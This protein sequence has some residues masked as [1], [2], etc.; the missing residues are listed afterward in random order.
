M[1]QHP[2]CRM[3]MS[4]NENNDSHCINYKHANYEKK[5][6]YTTAMIGRKR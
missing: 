6:N 5:K 3:A 4:L 2:T 1:L